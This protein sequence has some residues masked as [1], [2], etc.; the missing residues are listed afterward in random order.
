MLLRVT[1]GHLNMVLNG[2]RQSRSLIARWEALQVKEAKRMSE[3]NPR[4]SLG[5][6]PE[7]AAASNPLDPAAAN[8]C[9]EWVDLAGKLGF[10]V[11]AVQAHYCEELWAVSGFEKSLG[12]ELTEAN[13]GHLDSVK[14]FNPI[15]FYF[16]V[17]TQ[18]LA[19]GL[20]LIKARMA[21]IGLLPRVKIG[22]ADQESRTYR[23]LYPEAEKVGT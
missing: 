23:T 12:R 9:I 18:N 3:Q 19:A 1:L 2:H 6:A 5:S 7:A 15:T 17:N 10:T 8:E 11:V 13:L 14:W 21:A 22:C 20:L 4:F 16:L